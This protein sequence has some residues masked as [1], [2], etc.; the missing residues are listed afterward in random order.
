MICEQTA[1]AT[2]IKDRQA[3]IRFEDTGMGLPDEMAQI[4]EPFFTTKEPGKGTGLGLAIC[5]DIIEKYNGKII[6]QRRSAGGAIF[7]ILIP[8]ES[9]AAIR[10][11]RKISETS[12][13]GSSFNTT[14]TENSP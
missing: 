8:L 14:V 9:C 10:S 7:T 3:V 1:I 6:P 5:K 13:P 2:E 4:F 12:A 11:D